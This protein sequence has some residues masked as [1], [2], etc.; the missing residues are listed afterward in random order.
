MLPADMP[1][2]KEPSSESRPCLLTILRHAR[3]PFAVVSQ[4]PVKL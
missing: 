4:V 3:L 2:S 1:S